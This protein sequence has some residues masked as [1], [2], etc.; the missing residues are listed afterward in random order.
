[1]STLLL[2]V[3]K[4]CK[5]IIMKKNHSTNKSRVCKNSAFSF[6][7]NSKNKWLLSS[8]EDLSGK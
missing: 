4:I 1:M 8:R 6:F 2:D 5:K 3:R 7:F